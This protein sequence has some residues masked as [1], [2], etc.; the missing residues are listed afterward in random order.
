MLALIVE[1][2]ERDAIIDAKSLDPLGIETT[3]MPNAETAIQYCREHVID[4]LICHVILKDMS[5]YEVLAAI[6][7]DQPIVVLMISKHPVNLIRS[8][9]GFDRDVPVLLEPFT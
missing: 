4:I 7:K 3:W 6:S 8:V 9:R 2:C 1:P 5:G